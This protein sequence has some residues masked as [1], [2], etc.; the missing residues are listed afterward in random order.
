MTTT[1]KVVMA[2]SAAALVVSLA[3]IGYTVVSN[4]ARVTEIQTSRYD[5]TFSACVTRD[6]E[7]RGIHLFVDAL[8]RDP[9]RAEPL[10]DRYFPLRA[11]LRVPGRPAG[12]VVALVADACRDFAQR[13]VYDNAK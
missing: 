4:S 1:L 3:A 2:V 11:P 6:R 10:L 8:A 9:G 12:T 7:H 13:R 5:A